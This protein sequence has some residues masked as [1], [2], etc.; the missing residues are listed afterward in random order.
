MG[1]TG[2]TTD[3]RAVTSVEGRTGAVDVVKADVGLGSVDNTADADK[4]VSSATTTALA[5]KANTSHTHAAGA[6]T[7]PDSYAANMSSTGS[8]YYTVGSR[9][10]PN[11]TVRLRGRIAAGA[12]YTAGATI[13]TLHTSARPAMEVAFPVRV[14]GV[15]AANGSLTITTAGLVT[16]SANITVGA[17]TAWLLDGITYTLTA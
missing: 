13:C 12:N 3:A 7:V 14:V 8:P 5:G 1:A 4:P 2:Y 15:G 11:D 17:G 10:E 9:T 16:Y 6:W